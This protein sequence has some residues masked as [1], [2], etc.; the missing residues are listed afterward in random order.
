MNQPVTATG[1]SFADVI[2]RA[3]SGSLGITPIVS[4]GPN[5]QGHD[6]NGENSRPQNQ[7]DPFLLLMQQI[8]LTVGNPGDYVHDQ[9][10]LDE[11]ITRLMDQ[12]S[13]YN[14]F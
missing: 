8:G 1:T 3:I 11:I 7:L 14:Y 9:A 4:S 2:S 13:K 12:A 5:Q 6:E 10:T